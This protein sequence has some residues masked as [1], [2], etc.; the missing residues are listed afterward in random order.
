MH[1]VGD[2][3]SF[4]LFFSSCFFSDAPYSRNFRFVNGGEGGNG[5][6]DDIDGSTYNII[7]MM[8]MVGV[9]VTF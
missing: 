6:D 4:N 8:E 5:G 3:F 2:Q 9:S 1:L 7:I